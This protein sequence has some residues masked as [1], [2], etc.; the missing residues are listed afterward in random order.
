V[1]GTKLDQIHDAKRALHAIMAVPSEAASFHMYGT[2]PPGLVLQEVSVIN[3]LPYR[4]RRERW[5]RLHVPAIN[6]TTVSQAAL[7]RS[8]NQPKFSTK[9]IRSILRNLS[10]LRIPG[11]YQQFILMSKAKVALEEAKIISKLRESH[12]AALPNAIKEAAAALEEDSRSKLWYQNTEVTMSATVGQVLHRASPS[13]IS[14]YTE[15]SLNVANSTFLPTVPNLSLLLPHLPNCS[16][17]KIV[18]DTLSFRLVQDTWLS[19]GNNYFPEIRMEFKVSSLGEK[20]QTAEFSGMYAIISDLSAYALLPT[21]AVDVRFGRR[22]VIRMNPECIDVDEKIRTYIETTKQSIL[23]P[24]ALRAPQ[25]INIPLP[26]WIINKVVQPPQKGEEMPKPVKKPEVDIATWSKCLLGNYS[27]VGVEHRET[28]SFNLNGFDLRYNSVEAG[29]IGG[30]YG[31]LT[32]MS[33]KVEQ[34]SGLDAQAV[35]KVGKKP[36]RNSDADKQRVIDAIKEREPFVKS[37]FE[38]VELIEQAVQGT[39]GAGF[40]QI[41]KEKIPEKKPPKYWTRPEQ[42]LD[43]GNEEEKM[44]ALAAG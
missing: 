27:F 42:N 28:L 26:A 13:T 38:L 9:L 4:D 37:A 14:E 11:R 35:A 41:K 12:S 36:K 15:N 17:E 3:S 30:H 10:K 1:Y 18:K 39:L 8:G 24:G 32:I 6:S 20:T 7:T 5:T 33:S 25:H 31:E 29:K 16:E 34:S 40:G 19:S 22:T 2:P 43:Q 21:C 23:V 44:S